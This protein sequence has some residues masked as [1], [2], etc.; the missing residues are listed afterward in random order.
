M[1]SFGPL[2]RGWRVDTTIDNNGYRHHKLQSGPECW[3]EVGDLG[4]GSYGVVCQELCLSG[5]S[6]NSM[7]AVKHVLKRQMF[8]ETRR[9][10]DALVTFS[11]SEFPEVGEWNA[12]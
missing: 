10:L 12:S 6:K 2:L 7:R 5:R 3:K 11:N 4:S 1:D 8:S 9:E